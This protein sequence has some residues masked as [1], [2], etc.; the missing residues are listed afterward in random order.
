MVVLAFEPTQ[1]L[2]CSIGRHVIDGVDPVAER[3]DVAD[4]LLDEDVLV[5]HE[6]DSDDL[7]L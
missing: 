1:D 6:D 2:P 3:R 5:V 7:R 4:R